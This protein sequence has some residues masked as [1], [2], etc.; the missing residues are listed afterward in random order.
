MPWR[1]I[2]GMRDHVVHGYDAV[3]LEEVWNTLKRDIPPL[4]AWLESHL[5]I[6][7]TA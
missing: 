5:A 6:E 3:D 2:A 1:Q 4:I 7:G